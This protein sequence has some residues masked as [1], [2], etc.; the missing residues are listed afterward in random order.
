MLS[1]SLAWTLETGLPL[2]GE[3]PEC[4]DTIVSVISEKATNTVYS[5]FPRYGSE[6][7]ISVVGCCASTFYSTDMPEYGSRSGIRLTSRDFGDPRAYLRYCT[8]D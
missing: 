2:E 4:W 1:L 5:F 7:S 8:T 3:I 6:E